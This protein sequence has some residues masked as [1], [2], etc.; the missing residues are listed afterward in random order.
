[1]AEYYTIACIYHIIFIHSS[2]DG[3]LGCSQVLTIV[4][5]AAVNTG[6]HASFW[7]IV[8]SGYMARSKTPGLW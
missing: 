3:H 2:T 8:L 4:N 1:M 5:S 7:I 6:L